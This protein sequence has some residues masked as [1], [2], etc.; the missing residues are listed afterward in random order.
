[1]LVLI[2][3]VVVVVVNEDN[4]SEKVKPIAQLLH[5]YKTVNKM[6]NDDI[7]INFLLFQTFDLV[8][9]STLDENMLY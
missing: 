3:V 9:S 4:L 6:E 2:V 5:Y 7:L 8:V 1:M